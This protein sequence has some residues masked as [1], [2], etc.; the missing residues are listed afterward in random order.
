MV[1][2]AYGINGASGISR[3]AI[4]DNL[5]HDQSLVVAHRLRELY[6][7]NDGIVFTTDL[8]Q[9]DILPTF[10][11]APV[12]WAVHMSVFP[13]SQLPE[14]KER[15]YHSLYYSNVSPEALHKL[16]TSRSYV[17]S[18][19]LF[20]HERV[21]SHFVSDFKPV[22]EAEISQEVQL[23]ADYAISFSRANA[24]RYVL[25]YFIVPAGSEFDASTL[26]RW[27]ERDGGERAGEFMIYQLKLKP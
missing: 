26:D 17:V 1:S 23:Y 8:R 6:R 27:Y 20:A 18:I 10:A 5:I 2:F 25:G 15:F 12:L 13:G 4:N 19:A 21:A 9:G 22:T 16:L 24:A 3:A 7:Q 14:L 11:P